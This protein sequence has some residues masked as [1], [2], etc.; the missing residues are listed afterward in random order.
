MK[1][2]VIVESPAKARTIEKFLGPNYIVKASMGHI[3]DLPKSKI[4]VDFDNN[5]K[6]NY[7]ISEDKKKIV[8]ELKKLAK[9]KKVFLATDEDREGEAIAWHLLFALGIKEKDTERIVFHQITKKAILD[10]FEKSRG[11]NKGL[12]DAQQARRVIDRLV[13]YNLSPLLWKKVM[14]GLSAGRVQSVAVKLVVEKER[15]I[16]AFNPEEFW[17]IKVQLGKQKYEVAAQ[18]HK[19]SNKRKKIENS[20]SANQIKKDIGDSNFFV[21]DVKESDAKRNPAPP[22]TTSTL[23]QEASRKLG[24]SV[25]RTM[26]VAQRLYEGIN[27]KSGRTGLITYMRTDSFNLANEAINDADKYI[28]KNFGTEYA[29]GGRRFKTKSKNAQEAHEAI[30]PVSF[31]NSPKLISTNLKPD[32]Y[33][34]YSLIWNRAMASQMT[35]AK[36]KKTKAIFS[37]LS[38]DKYDFL[39]EG[40]KIVFDGFMRVYFES[41]DDPK[42]AEEHSEKFLPPIKEKEEWEQKKLDL[43]QNFTKPPARYTEA[44]LVKKLESEGIGRPSTYAPTISTIINRGYVEKIEKKLHPTDRAEVVVDFLQKYFEEVMDYKFTAHIEEKFD[45][46]EDKKEKWVTVVKNFYQ[47]FIKNVEITEEKADKKDILHTK[48]LG[49][50]PKTGKPITARIGPY[51]PFAQLGSKDDKDKDGKEIKPKFASLLPGQKLDTLTLDDAL[52]L[53]K[54]PRIVGKDNDGNEITTNF[55]RFG[56]YIKFGSVFVSIKGSK[57]EGTLDENPFT[58]TL[59]KSLEF[60]EQKKQQLIERNIKEFKNSDIKIL[61]GRWGPYVNQGKKNAKIPK[62]IEDPSKLTLAECKKILKEYKPRGRGKVVKKTTVKK[63]TSKKE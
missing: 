37:P 21:K 53:F 36:M 52:E 56:P 58:I 34:L 50:D 7:E 25:S 3:R 47:P 23:Q 49:T 18:L 4:G 11:I 38:A 8:R 2:L 44:S 10:S 63:K 30:R 29:S 26:M 41:F 54:L 62:E 14:R 33:K 42:K 24:F 20:K 57:K 22:F 59:E 35:S 32:E 46:I 51:G 5:F 9:G 1:N 43:E 39:A 61:K 40:L 17:K 6:P 31:S 19:I 60:I 45:K 15:E 12:V 13:G 27:L 48:E 28:K 16:R 55:G